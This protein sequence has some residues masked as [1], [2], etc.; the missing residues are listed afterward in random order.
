MPKASPSGGVP[1]RATAIGLDRRP[2]R[3]HRLSLGRGDADR[4]R[5]DAAELVALAPDVVL[6]SRQPGRRAV[7]RRPGPYRSCLRPSATRS[8]LAIVTSLA[9]PGGNATG[10]MPF[11][12]GIGTKWLELLK[13]I[14]PDVRRVA[15]L[16]DAAVASGIGQV[17]A[18]Q[19]AAPSLGVEVVP[20]NVGDASEIEQRRR[21][22]C[23][24]GRMAV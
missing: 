8:A 13:E 7:R 11:E 16:R 23:A 20:V 3:A 6:A 19:A 9:R 21:G 1:A 10:F 2:Q 22:V 4:F 5:R 14:A 15:V 18:I 24:R 12:Y 17:G